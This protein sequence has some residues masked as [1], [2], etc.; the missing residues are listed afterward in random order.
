MIRLGTR[1][2][3]P[4]LCRRSEGVLLLLTAWTA[5]CA[6]AAYTAAGAPA[7]DPV[8]VADSLRRATIPAAPQQVS[9]A[10]S[11]D[12]QGTPLR[13]RGVARYQAPQR[14][15]VDLFGPRGETYLAAAL[16]GD[17]LR[18]PPGAAAGIQLP[19]PA[20]LWGALGVLRPPSGAVPVAALRDGEMLVVRYR[21]PSSSQEFA[22]EADPEGLAGVQRLDGST[23]LE[24]LRLRRDTTGLRSA[25]YRDWAAYRTLTLAFEGAPAA[26]LFD[27]AIWL[28]GNAAR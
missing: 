28:T 22:F 15:R 25:E 9:F 16:V 5:G 17:S 3:L 26:A 23:R 12:E 8:A 10:W 11:L 6:P 19:S 24:S 20:L 13:G 2:R 18:L 4:A 7:A 1:R 27:P 21:D 14:L